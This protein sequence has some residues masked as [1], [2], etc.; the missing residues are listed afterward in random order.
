MAT[1]V[2]LDGVTFTDTDFVDRGH[3]DSVSVGGTA[4]PRFQALW[5]A[6]VNEINTK[7]GQIGGLGVAMAYAAETGSTADAAPG[8]GKLTWNNATQAS[9]TTIYLDA[10]DA[11]GVDITALIDTLDDSDSTIKGTLRLTQRDDNTKW[12]VYNLTAVTSA[13]GYRKLTVAAVD[14]S[15]TTPFA[16]GANL[17]LTFSRTGDKGET[18]NVGDI[19]AQPAETTVAMD[20]LVVIHDSTAGATRKMTVANLLGS[21]AITSMTVTALTAT[22]AT[23][24]TLTVS[25]VSDLR[26]VV[27]THAAGQS[28]LSVN[29]SAGST[30]TD[31]TVDGEQFLYLNL[32]AD[33]TIN[34]FGGEPDANGAYVPN[35]W[36]LEIDNDVGGSGGRDLTIQKGNELTYSADLQ[37]TAEAGETRPWV[38]TNTSLTLNAATGP[39][40]RT[41]LQKMVEDANSGQHVRYVS[42]TGLSPNQTLTMSVIAGDAGDGRN[43]EILLH[44]TGASANQLKWIVNPATGATVFGPANGGN[45][46]GATGLATSLDN[47]CWRFDLTGQP[48]TSGSNTTVQVG[49]YTSQSSYSGDGSS[50]V[51]IGNVQVNPG[52]PKGMIEVGASRALDAWLSDNGVEPVWTSQAAGTKTVVVIDPPEVDGTLTASRVR[53][54]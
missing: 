29:E 52:Q 18:G 44:D 35:G 32:T 9:A 22:T 16:D 3:L 13:T 30:A 51:Y 39:D 34:V 20:D 8:D 27:Q 47:G 49:L 14:Y 54:G 4:Y 17:T 2:T 45:A 5:V 40:G 26:G 6:G 24:T 12:I 33:H 53:G 28:K 46:A 42:V 1:S 50:G 43:L 31:L 15:A 36:R 11:N 10:D 21:T 48:N 7:V 37:S 25:G 23:V 41:T 19:T 38:D